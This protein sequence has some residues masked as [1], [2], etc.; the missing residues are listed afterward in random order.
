MIDYLP[1]LTPSFSAALQSDSNALSLKQDFAR[2][3]RA[4]HDAF[5]EECSDAEQLDSR[6]DPSFQAPLGPLLRIQA[7]RE[8]G[9]KVFMTESYWH[10]VPDLP[11]LLAT[12]LNKWN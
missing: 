4:S 12:R 1:S 9:S 10:Q 7:S 11:G 5:Y 6:T 2:S 8:T 3:Y